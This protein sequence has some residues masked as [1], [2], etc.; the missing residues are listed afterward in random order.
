M[1]KLAALELEERT[2]QV[3][4]QL[5]AAAGA[6]RAAGLLQQPR[7]RGHGAH[8]H[9]LP[10]TSRR[11]TCS[12]ST[13]AGCTRRPTPCS[14]S[15]SIATATAS[16]WWPRMPQALERLVA[17]QGVNGFYAQRARPARRAA[18]C[19]RSSPSGARSPATGPG[20]P[21]CAAS[22]RPSAPRAAPQEWDARYGLHK[23]SPLL[24]W[25]EAEVWQYIRARELP[26]NILHDRQYPSIGCSPCTRAIQPGE[27]RRAG[28]W[29]WEQ[30]E[31]RECGL[32]PRIRPRGPRRPAVA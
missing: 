27:S 21:A 13:P 22:S 11:S 25:S 12:A 3:R 19:A 17:G 23:V 14:R 30:T 20:S 9:H 31:S 7:R 26:Y 16:G 15:C 29:W 32:Q 18:G 4:A 28:R 2:A 6:V 8:G 10:R 5:A 24:D 1:G